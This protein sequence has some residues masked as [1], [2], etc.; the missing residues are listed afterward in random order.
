MVPFQWIFSH[1]G[2]ATGLAGASAE[3]H[4]ITVSRAIL[5]G[6]SRLETFLASRLG[7]SHGTTRDQATEVSTFLI[8]LTKTTGCP[9]YHFGG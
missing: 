1:G 9:L 7:L 8:S 6:I 3:V 2:C 4:G 5:S